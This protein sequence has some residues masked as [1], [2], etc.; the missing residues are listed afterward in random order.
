[1]FCEA[2]FPYFVINILVLGC[3]CTPL[4]LVMLPSYYALPNSWPQYHQFFC[5]HRRAKRWLKNISNRKGKHPCGTGSQTILKTCLHQMFPPLHFWSIVV[6]LHWYSKLLLSNLQLD[7]RLDIEVSIEFVSRV[8][9]YVPSI[10]V[11]HSL[12]HWCKKMKT[13]HPC[14]LHLYSTY[15]YYLLG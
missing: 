5:D 9:N 8:K 7:K 2:L 15:M 12:I 14:T 10:K 3:T 13:L 1:M 6:R 4:G 11:V